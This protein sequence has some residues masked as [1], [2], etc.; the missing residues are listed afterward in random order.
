[1]DLKL[2]VLLFQAAFL[3]AHYNDGCHIEDKTVYTGT[4][5]NFFTN[6]STVF[7]CASYCRADDHC[8]YW[9]LYKEGDHGLGGYCDLWDNIEGRRNYRCAISGT[10][11]CGETKMETTAPTTTLATP[12]ISEICKQL[13][14]VTKEC[15]YDPEILHKMAL[16]GPRFEPEIM[17]TVEDKDDEHDEHCDGILKHLVKFC[18]IQKRHLSTLPTK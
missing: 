10:G 16:N 3:A 4:F 15:G 6:V 18:G 8:S 11:T 5:L 17:N 1:M 2:V 7:Q 9:T 13:F 14:N 12:V